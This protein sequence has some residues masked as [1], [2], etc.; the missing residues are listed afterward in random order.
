MVT[1]NTKFCKIPIKFGFCLFSMFGHIFKMAD[2]LKI[3]LTLIFLS[4][5]LLLSYKVWSHSSEP[6][7]RYGIVLIYDLSFVYIETAAILKFWKPNG[8]TS[9]GNLSYGKVPLRSFNPSLRI[10]SESFMSGRKR[11]I[12]TRFKVVIASKSQYIPSRTP[13]G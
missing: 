6:F 13:F 5:S 12:I 4:Y 3:F 9:S 11:I 10:R 7:S 8:T 2:I 1:L